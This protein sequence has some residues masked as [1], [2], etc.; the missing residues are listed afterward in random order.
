MLTTIIIVLLVLWLL[1]GVAPLNNGASYFGTAPNISYIV[2][3]ILVIFLVVELLLP[4][5]HRSL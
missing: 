3:V 1:G 2:A 4:A 5:L